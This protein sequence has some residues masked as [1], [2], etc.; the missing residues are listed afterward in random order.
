MNENCLHHVALCVADFEWHLSFFKEVF[1]MSVSRE[2]GTAGNRQLWFYEG[3]QII[4]K[5]CLLSAE[6]IV[7]HI[8]VSV[9][10]S[11][12]VITKA[13]SFG[14]TLPANHDNWIVLPNGLQIE[15]M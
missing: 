10:D 2:T 12:D 5:Q 3:I 6:H 9:L 8:A 7:D 11:K 1:G 4:E 13:V 14:C 15:L